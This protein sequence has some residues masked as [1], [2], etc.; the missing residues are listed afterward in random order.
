LTPPGADD[1]YI[2]VKGVR[3][4]LLDWG[5]EG[6]AVLCVHANGYLAA[7]WHPIALDLRPQLRVLALDLPGCGDSAPA[8]SYDW[9]ELADYV[10]GTMRA[11][12]LG[13]YL[14]VG[15]SM[16]G[17]FS[18]ICAARYP[19]LVRGIVLAD[20]VIL[21]R[22]LYANPQAAEQSDFYGARKRRRSWP[23][24]EAMRESLEGRIPYSRWRRE[25]FDL[26]VQE[27]VRESED[28]EVALKCSP[29][30]EV[31]VYR[32][33]LYYDLWPEIARADVP[34]IVLRGLSAEGFPSTTAP[35]L[36]GW[37]PRGEDQPLAESSHHVPME[38]PEEVIRAVRDLLSG[39]PS[40]GSSPTR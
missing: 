34:A 31:E 11:L 40:P 21:E 2:D 18:A 36:A 15:H 26:F 23:S 37:L 7:L 33:T 29:D 9:S 6:Q 38:R 12:G 1:T 17:A 3:L 10:G 14:L 5:G 35:S 4:H 13:P 22:A 20:P 27:A 39:I 16:G 28:G 32:Q 25:F 30:T 8:P 19:E 24:R